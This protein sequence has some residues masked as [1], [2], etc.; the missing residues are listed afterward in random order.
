MLFVRDMGK[1]DAEGL[2]FLRAPLEN[3][4]SV[5]PGHSREPNSK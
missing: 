4:M 2:L 3:E 5:S 1:K